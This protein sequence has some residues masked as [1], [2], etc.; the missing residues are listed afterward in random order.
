M[1]KHYEL[2][3]D[4]FETQFGRCELDP[5]HFSHEAHLRLAWIHLDKYGIEQAENRME[6]QLRSFV[7]FIGAHDKYNKTLTLAAIRMLHQYRS[8]S[9]SENFKGFIREFPELKHHFNDLLER[10]Y[11]F[12][13]HDSPEAKREFIQPDLL[14]FD[15]IS[16]VNK[17]GRS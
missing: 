13:I 10:H 16:P 9:R 3:D 11:S 17:I 5:A 1:E 2:T 14:P 7:E 8:M 12:D 4:E 15:Q 6:K